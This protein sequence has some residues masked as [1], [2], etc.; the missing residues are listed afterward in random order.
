M[1][2]KTCGE[3]KKSQYNRHDCRR[4]EMP[5]LKGTTGPRGV[6]YLYYPTIAPVF[7]RALTVQCETRILY[8]L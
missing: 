7:D 8:L 1:R 2:L 6:D 3:R 5:A 4:N